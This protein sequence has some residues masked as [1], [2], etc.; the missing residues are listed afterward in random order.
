MGGSVGDVRADL[1]DW[2]ANSLPFTTESPHTLTVQHHCGGIAQRSDTD[3]SAA[4]N[5]HIKEV[6]RFLI[7]VRLMVSQVADQ[8][9][10]RIF[11]PWN[12]SLRGE[13]GGEAEEEGAGDAQGVE[14][15]ES[16]MVEE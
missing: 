2:S 12:F 15:E 4:Q 14:D 1:V 7:L 9:L 6:N 13:E 11:T 10:P 16:G 5:L 3:T 8:R